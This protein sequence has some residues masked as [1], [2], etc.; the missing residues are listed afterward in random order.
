MLT[1]NTKA[2]INEQQYGGKKKK[3]VTNPFK[4][5]QTKPKPRSK[6]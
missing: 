3:K 1:Y 5:L 2:F 4:H 6:K